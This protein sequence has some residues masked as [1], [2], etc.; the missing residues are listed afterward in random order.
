MF[1]YCMSTEKK[2]EI[3][4]PGSRSKFPLHKT[5]Y[6]AKSLKP[7]SEVIAQEKVGSGASSTTRGIKRKA[8][9]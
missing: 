6:R 8:P 4:V 1:V 3:V 9:P 7:N 2:M 5:I